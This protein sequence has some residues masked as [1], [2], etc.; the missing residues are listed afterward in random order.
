LNFQFLHTEFIWAFAASIFFI[1]LFVL[2]L[3]W[4]R[5]T[6]QK[7]GDATLVKALIKT[8]SPK[9]F[10]LKFGL[11]SAA[12][13]AAVLMV[14]DLRKPGD[15]DG[16]TRKGIDVVIALDVS[17]SMLATDMAPSRLDRAKQLIS[18]LMDAMPDDRIGLVVF[19]GKAYLQMP[20]TT[21]HSAARM[22]VSSASPGAVPQQGTVISDAL[23]MSANAFNAAERRFKTVIL[24]SDGEDH[25]AE[26]AN[27]AKA[28]A[29]QGMMVNTVG[30][31]SAEG[32]TIPD[33]LSGGNKTD[34]AGNEVVSKLNEDVLKQIA[35]STNGVYV[36]LQDSDEAITVLKQQL[37]QIESKAFGDISLMNF[38]A[39]YWWFA[40]AMLLLL[41][42]EFLIPETKKIKA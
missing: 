27:T 39:Y 15:A 2:L 5:K 23:Q 1:L 28:V 30:I 29:E 11:L 21:D 33:P 3:R 38:K 6:I 36:R 34:A 19:A 40:G 10:A 20:L 18:K 35:Q 31:G 12:F 4:K 16:V 42:V 7:I 37:S 22:F 17:K 26:A 25:D 14:M 13:G 41:L 24:I 8:Y 9:L 32:T